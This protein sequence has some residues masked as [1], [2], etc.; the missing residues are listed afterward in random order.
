MSGAAAMG[1]RGGRDARSNLT[2]GEDS[3][4]DSA[5]PF[6]AK[7]AS[8]PTSWSIAA[9]TTGILA[10]P[11]NNRGRP[12]NSRSW[13]ARGFWEAVLVPAAMRRDLERY[14]RDGSLAPARAEPLASALAIHSR[15]LKLLRAIQHLPRARAWLSLCEFRR[16]GIPIREGARSLLPFLAPRLE[17]LRKRYR[18]RIGRNGVRGQGAQRIMERY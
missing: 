12:V 2:H 7:S 17:I 5:V 10:A 4:A 3:V 13:N 14:V 9:F 6:S 11:I 15:R 16:L 18:G 1:A 8:F